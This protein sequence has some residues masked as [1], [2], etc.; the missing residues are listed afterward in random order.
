MSDPSDDQA[1]TPRSFGTR[2]VVL[3]ACVLVTLATVFLYAAEASL[4]INAARTGQVGDGKIFV[5]T[6]DEVVRIRTGETAQ[7]AV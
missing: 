2:G 7:A 5:S 3:V 1:D 4:T 6:L